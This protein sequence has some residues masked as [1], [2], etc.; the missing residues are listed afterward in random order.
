LWRNWNEIPNNGIDDDNNGYVDD[1]SGWDTADNDNDPRPNSSVQDH[2]TGVSGIADAATDNGIG[3]ASVAFNVKLMPIKAANF[4]GLLIGTFAGVQ[5]AVLNGAHVVNCSWGNYYYEQVFQDFVDVAYE[6]GVIIVA[7]AGNDDTNRVMYPAGYNH[8]IAV[9]ATNPTDD[10]KASYSNYGPQ[11]DVMAPS[12]MITTSDR[13]GGTYTFFSGTSGAS[14]LVASLIA[15]MRSARPDLSPEQIIQ[16]LKDACINI[17]S[18]NPG[19]EGM[20]GAGRIDAYNA[21]KCL[22]DTGYYACASTVY[23]KSFRGTPTLIQFGND[24]PA[25][26]NSSN[27]TAK[28]ERISGFVGYHYVGSLDAYFGKAVWRDSSST[29]Q[30]SVWTYDSLTKGPGTLIYTKSYPI[31]Q[32]AEAVRQQ[33]AVRVWFDS[34]VAIAHPFFVGI[35]FTYQPGDTVALLTNSISDPQ[36]SGQTWV[37]YSSGA[38]DQMENAWGKP[39]NLMLFPHLV[40]KKGILPHDLTIQQDSVNPYLYTFAIAVVGSYDSLVWDIG[41]TTV[42]NQLTFTYAYQHEGTY[43]VIVTIYKDT[44]SVQLQGT[45]TTP[46][47][48]FTATQVPDWK[49]FPNPI[50]RG[51]ILICRLPNLHGKKVKWCLYNHVGKLVYEEWKEAMVST[52]VKVLIPRW[53]APGLYF[54]FWYDDQNHWIGQ[55]KVLVQ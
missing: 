29:I 15:L 26:H 46:M 9:G 20:L 47:T 13:N 43:P 55:S 18:L 19:Y 21:L 5:Y 4:S 40:G 14:P 25:G 17:D 33:K 7:G 42:S 44:C 49:V 38:W 12:G 22:T 51:E 53:L 27:E 31:Y 11:I 45:V 2:G 28:A 34:L 36:K 24:Y 48:V 52:E 50:G 3:I 54:L 8:V 37:R 10:K 23:D 41:E 6:K 35:E 16:C 30:F 32:I 39:Y 1:T